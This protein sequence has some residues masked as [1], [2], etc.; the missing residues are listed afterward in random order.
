MVFSGRPTRVETTRAQPGPRDV[1]VGQAEGCGRLTDSEARRAKGARHSS[2]AAADWRTLLAEFFAS[3]WSGQQAES[4]VF[5]K[6]RERERLHS[7]AN[8]KRKK[9]DE[10]TLITLWTYI[11]EQ[12]PQGEKS[13]GG[14]GARTWTV[15]DS[16]APGPPVSCL[17]SCSCE[18]ISIFSIPGGRVQV[19]PGLLRYCGCMPPML[20]RTVRQGWTLGWDV[21]PLI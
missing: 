1:R 14:G 9:G 3:P 11:Q 10:L 6:N 2:L 20:C 15:P 16:G 21:G 17:S 5:A 4:F 12:G 18:P 8:L 19:G 7:C 13:C